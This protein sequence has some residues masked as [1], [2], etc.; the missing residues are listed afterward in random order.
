MLQQNIQQLYRLQ[1]QPRLIIDLNSLQLWRMQHKSRCWREQK[2]E[3]ISIKVFATNTCETKWNQVNLQGENHDNLVL[4]IR[5]FEQVPNSR[6]QQSGPKTNKC[7][8]HHESPINEMIWYYRRPAACPEKCDDVLALNPDML[9]NQWKWGNH[10][11]L[12]VTWTK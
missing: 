6:Y 8:H 4:W 5:Q 3:E 1:L 9:A 10:V 2:D 7:W 12:K 11:D